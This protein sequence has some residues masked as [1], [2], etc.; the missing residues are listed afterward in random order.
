MQHVRMVGA[1]PDLMARIGG[2]LNSARKRRETS[3]AGPVE[4]DVLARIRRPLK[5]EPERIDGTGR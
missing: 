4:R 2:R 3:W 1:G 5:L